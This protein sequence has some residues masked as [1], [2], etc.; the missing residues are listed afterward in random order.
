M[1]MVLKFIH[2]KNLHT[3]MEV[4]VQGDNRCNFLFA[5]MSGTFYLCCRWLMGQG[6][7]FWHPL[8]NLHVT[9]V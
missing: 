1:A 5:F 6:R 3:F 2:M 4:Q 9:L 8:S 7:T